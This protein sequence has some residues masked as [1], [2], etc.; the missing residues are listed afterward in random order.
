MATGHSVLVIGLPRTGKTTFLAALWDV[1]ETESVDGSLILE[2]IEGDKEHLNAIRDLWANC[3]EMPRTRVGK[4]KTVSMKLRDRSSNISGHFS[5]PD[6][7]GETFEQ[8]WTDRVWTESYEKLVVS[9]DTVMLFV[10]PKK[11]LEGALIRDARPLIAALPK[12]DSTT[13]VVDASNVESSAEHAAPATRWV[14][15]QVQV[16]ELLQ[17][18]LR[19]R[20]SNR[21]RLGV[22]VSA[23]DMVMKLGSTTPDKWI[24]E[25]MPLLY[26]YLI[27]NRESVDF[28]VYGVSAQGGD[29]KKNVAA[30]RNKHKPCERIIIFEG[31]TE[32]T[33]ISLPVRWMMG[34]SK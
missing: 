14:P 5:F 27:S 9:S 20:G 18:V 15:T 3:D 1:V 23:W 6:M 25:R 10:H 30:L 21:M 29:Y 16:L 17:F 24:Q 2:S 22:I 13:N 19:K 28:R 8:Q 11:V 33:D 34:A 32:S 31:A 7:D 12:A 26:Q 4:E